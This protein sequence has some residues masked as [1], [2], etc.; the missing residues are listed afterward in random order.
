MASKSPAR[1][2][3]AAAVTRFGDWGSARW[4]DEVF[5]PAN[6]NRLTAVARRSYTIAQG[7][8]S[9]NC[10]RTRCSPGESRERLTAC[11]M[12]TGGCIELFAMRLAWVHLHVECK[13]EKEGRG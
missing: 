11:W 7:S 3:D 10:V 6:G 8:G 2:T 5:A 12:R 4:T 1:T 13:E 9:A